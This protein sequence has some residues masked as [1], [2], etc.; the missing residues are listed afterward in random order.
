MIADQPALLDSF[1]QSL[2][3]LYNSLE[4]ENSL[5]KIRAK[6]WERFIEL[7]LPTKKN[8]VFRYVP[9]KKLFQQR[10]ELANR[11]SLDKQTLEKQMIDPEM[12]DAHIL[13][14]CSQSVLVFINGLFSPSLSRTNQIPSRVVTTTLDVA[15]RT[16]SGF[17]QNQ[18]TKNLKD[19]SDPFSALNGAL[20]N[21]GL[22]L[23]VAPKTIVESPIQLLNLIDASTT[24]VLAM[25]RMQAF[26]GAQSEISIISTHAVVSGNFYGINMVVDFSIEE[27]AHVN[28][29]QI[30]SQ[31][32][33]D[34]WHF[35][36]VHAT[37][38][39]DSF[40]KTIAATDGAA[41]IR[42]DYNIILAGEN[43]EAKLNGIWMLS[44]KK[45]A[46]THIFVEH[47]AP[48]CRSLQ[49]FKGVLDDF[50]RSSFEGKI[51]VRQAA[52]KTEA[53][54]LNQNILLN[55]YAHADSKPNL[56]IFADDVKASHGA[57]IGQLDP[58]H[59]FY[60][61]TRGFSEQ[62][63][64]QLLVHGF[65]EEVIEMI[66]FPSVRKRFKKVAF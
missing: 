19:V 15:M 31:I 13:P 32:A 62:T 60:M 66:P 56:E 22:F 27:A 1:Q 44:E 2:E 40:L 35:D 29:T 37:L 36:A 26:I 23:Y 42:Y 53:F 57:T 18:W 39:R 47:Q 63:A 25:P 3:N 9:L 17:L 8:D 6:A 5:Q 38:K 30:A 50:S 20:H 14:E 21:D 48:N 59:I 24:P 65:C 16:Y 61:K 43:A 12:I 28:Y 58:D 41:T 34:I 33:G 54:Q 10:Y 11:Q 46:H 52:Q 7:G 45:E 64:K 49:L 55:D 4:T 51:M